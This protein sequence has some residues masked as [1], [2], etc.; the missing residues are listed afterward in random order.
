MYGYKTLKDV[1]S[2]RLATFMKTYKIEDNEA[3][4][5]TKS[6]F[7][8][9]ALPPCK[10]ELYQHFLRALHIVQMWSHASQHITTITSPIDYDWQEEDGKYISKWFDGE[11]LPDLQDITDDL[12]K[13]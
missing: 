7:E 11:Q 4:L 5:K 8:G 10:S 13:I 9:S 1:N 3:I 6:N 2:A 12:P